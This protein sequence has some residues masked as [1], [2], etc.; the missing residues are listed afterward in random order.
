MMID[1][2]LTMFELFSGMFAT[3]KCKNTVEYTETLSKKNI[4]LNL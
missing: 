1:I 4:L 2:L 3:L